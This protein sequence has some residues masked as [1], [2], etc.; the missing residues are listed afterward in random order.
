MITVTSVFIS[1]QLL[2]ALQVYGRS[3]L[4]DAQSPAMHRSSKMIKILNKTLGLQLILVLW[5]LY[6]LYI[7][8]MSSIEEIQE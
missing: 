6:S 8:D 2:S 1:W 5:E 3:P 4:S 7:W